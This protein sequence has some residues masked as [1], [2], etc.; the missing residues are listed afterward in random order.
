MAWY[1]DKV[2]SSYL[3]FWSKMRKKTSFRLRMSLWIIFY[4]ILLVTPLFLA[5]LGHEH[6]WRGFWIE[7]GVGLG[8]VGFTMMCLQ[9]LLTGKFNEIAPYFG[10][11]SVLQIHRYAG[12]ISYLFVLGHVLTMIIAN[13]EYAYYFHPGENAPRAFALIGALLSLT[14]VIITSIWRKELKISYELWLITHGSLSLFVVFIG[15]VHLIQV[16]FYIDQLWQQV[17]FIAMA[18]F[19]MSLLTYL[20][21]V[22]PYLLKKRPYEI[23]KVVS[24][25]DQVWTVEVIPK[26]HEGFKF[27]AGQFAR[28]ILK[29]SPF[30]YEQNPFSISSSDQAPKIITFTIKEFGDFGAKIKHLKKGQRVFVDGPYGA[31]TIKEGPAASLMM[32]MGGIGITPGMSIIR[33]L[34]DRKDPRKIVLIYANKTFEDIIFK[35]ELNQLQ[36]EI[37]LTVV[38]VL[39][40]PPDDWKGEEGFVDEDLLW[41][42]KISEGQKVLYYVCGPGPLM[43]VA[44][45]TFIKWGEPARDIYSER[46]DIV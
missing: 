34:R 40:S 35:E 38:H 28:L 22:I 15:T 45:S 6:E 26:G 18:I 14:I 39:E 29:S 13:P 10:A 17:L 12:I 32:V 19:S 9:F 2:L 23:S 5:Q 24:E 16:G 25:A 3:S 27:K 41:K 42:Y 43:D 44:E 20:R 1:T 31:F 4:G 8:L 46:F 7:F 33:S 11:D 21:V 30:T 37:D 36:R